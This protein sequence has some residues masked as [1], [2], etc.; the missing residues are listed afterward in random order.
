LHDQGFLVNTVTAIP[1]YPAGIV[2]PGYRPWR[3]ARESISGISTLRCP[4]YPSH[5][6]SAGRRALNYM[7]FAITATWAGR[8]ILNSADVAL[9]YSSPA[10]AAL[11]AIVAHRRSGVPYVLLIQDLWP[12]TVLQ[13]AMV[14]S[15]SLRRLAATVLGSFDRYSTDHA[16]H[17]IVISPGMKE[18]LVA[19]GVQEDKITVMF[20]WID[21]SV[22]RPRPRSGS[23]RGR[24]A[25]PADDLVFMYAG[26][27]GSAQGLQAWIS[28]IERTQDLD[29]LHCVFVGS[30]TEKTQL[31]ARAAELRL[32]RT[33][34][35]NPV[36]VD[37]FAELAADADAQIISLRDAPLFNIT[38]PGKVQS[39][40]ALQ[41]AIVASVSGD[42]A[43][44]LTDS[45]AG[46]LA[47]PEDPASIERAIRQAHTEG[48]GILTG[49]G[50][51][52]YKY[53]LG[54]MSR[55]RG[56]AILASVL[57]RASRSGRAGIS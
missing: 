13:T 4:V 15:D 25:I 35:V 28:A 56:S 36:G 50:E 29:N 57:R 21:E 14:E 37:E 39:C 19:R 55:E 16:S 38:I 30:G 12:D 3:V 24:L 8:R 10:T 49:R 41:S 48:R 45:G 7:S 32:A 18:A 54:S 43:D 9:I 34:F 27:H 42:A 53:Y 1:N 26:N 20:N 40:L 51:A 2:Y 46:I 5:D 31:A 47:T 33:H 52:G 11:P 22:L 6:N 23:L 44:V 17:I